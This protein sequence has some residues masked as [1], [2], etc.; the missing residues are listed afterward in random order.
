M[1][2]LFDED[3]KY[4]YIFIYTEE[5]SKQP[6]SHGV[7]YFDK[8]AIDVPDEIIKPLLEA[9]EQEQAALEKVLIWCAQTGNTF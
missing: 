1:R 3:E 6:Y 9:R 8:N 4:P 2:V 5:D 7:E